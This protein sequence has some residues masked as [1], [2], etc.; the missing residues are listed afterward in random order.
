MGPGGR[1]EAEAATVLSVLRWL[2]SIAGRYR[3]RVLLVAVTGLLVQGAS[4]AGGQRDSGLLAPVGVTTT[5][6]QPTCGAVGRPST[7]HRPAAARTTTRPPAS[8]VALIS[9]SPT[10]LVDAAGRRWSPD[11]GYVG[12]R[13][14]VTDAQI[15]GTGSPAIYRHERSAMSGYRIPVPASGTYAVDL[16]LAE[17]TFSQPRQRVFDVS[18]EGRVEASEVDIAGAVGSN[19]AHHVIFTAAVT[20]GCLDLGFTAKVGEAKVSGIEVAFMRSS[21]AAGRLVWSDEFSG[22]AKAPVDRRRWRHEIGG[23]WGD[24]ELQSYT[25][26][27]ANS[28]QDGRG[29]LVIATRAERFSGADAI[30]RN[31]TSARISTMGRFSFRYGTFE[32]RLRTPAGRGLWPAFWALGTDIDRSGWP[33]CGEIDVMENLGQEPRRAYGTIHGPTGGG[34]PL[35]DYKPGFAVEHDAPLAQGFHTY[36]ARWLPGSIEFFF[37]GRRYGA[38]T[39]ADLPAGSRWVFDH[40]FYLVL[41]VAVGGRWAGSP[42]ATTS[43]PQAMHVD[44]VRVYQ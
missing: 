18:A 28:Y 14:A 11:A 24:G 23:A 7:R 3:R 16:Y 2:A 5:A 1:P 41:N 31:Y 22:P 4:E 29:R 38:I 35:E 42:D 10:A 8:W 40:P 33:R 32:A 19:H 37:D 30:T 13:P 26:R 20:D 6:R 27:L 34:G 25:D 43:F 12:G 44:H 15:E 17:T 21:T 36:G 39:R 9:T